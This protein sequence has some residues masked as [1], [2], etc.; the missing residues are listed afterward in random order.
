MAVEIEPRQC[1]DLESLDI[2]DRQ[3]DVALEHLPEQLRHGH[4]EGTVLAAP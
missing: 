2:D 1:I 4:G 3:P